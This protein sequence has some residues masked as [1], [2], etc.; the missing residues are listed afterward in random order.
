MGG[1]NIGDVVRVQGQ[2]DQMTVEAVVDTT[3]TVMWFAK[4]SSYLQ[5]GE[6][7][8]DVLKLVLK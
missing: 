7:K 5:R 6:F 4:D 8:D 3:V 2:D 1:F